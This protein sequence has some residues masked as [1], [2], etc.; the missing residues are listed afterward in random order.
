MSNF[1]V[2]DDHNESLHLEK[3][4]YSDDKEVVRPKITLVHVTR[5][6]AKIVEF[7]YGEIKPKFWE[8]EELNPSYCTNRLKPK[9]QEYI[10]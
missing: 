6:K 7:H 10:S 2:K 1:E 8:K 9:K 3:I 5:R 4:D